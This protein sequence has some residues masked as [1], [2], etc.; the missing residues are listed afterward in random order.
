MPNVARL[1]QYASILTTEF[2]ETT[3]NNVGITGLGTYYAS[4]FN[5]NIQDSTVV[6][7]GLVLHLDASSYVGSGTTWTDLSGSGNNAN[8]GVGTTVAVYSNQNLGKFTFDG[9]NDMM[10]I[11]NSN[12]LTSLNNISFNFWVRPTAFN[13]TS[14]N[15][16]TLIGKGVAFPTSDGRGEYTVSINETGV[17]FELG[18]SG[19]SPTISATY[20]FTANNWYNVCCTW[21]NG[22]VDQYAK[23]RIYVNNGLL[24]NFTQFN[25]L[26]PTYADNNNPVTIGTRTFNTDKTIFNGYHIGDIAIVSM[27]NRTLTAAEVSQNYNAFVRRFATSS[28][29]ISANVF[30]PYDPVNDEFAGVLYGPG[31]GTYMRQYT[32]KSVVIYNEID[33]ITSFA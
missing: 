17:F 11:P 19:V 24:T 23:F 4:E 9:I 6:T 30:A 20:P 14:Y 26:V 21:D 27:Y 29:L 32:D 25:F 3:S 12:S 33:E 13:T 31:Q 2:D 15:V 8:I 7:N 28:Q 5:E 16:N 18:P 22:A 1:D 10:L